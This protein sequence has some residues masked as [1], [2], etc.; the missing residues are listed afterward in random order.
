MFPSCWEVGHFPGK[1]K[2]RKAPQ[3]LPSHPP[4][5]DQSSPANSTGW[6]KATSRKAASHWTEMLL[7]KIQQVFER[8]VEIVWKLLKSVKWNTQ[9]LQ[10]NISKGYFWEID[11]NWRIW[12]CLTQ[13]SPP[14]PSN[15]YWCLIEDTSVHRMLRSIWHALHC[16]VGGPAYW[17]Y[18]N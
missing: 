2:S 8:G 15:K 3:S 10:Y 13:D 7:Q 11:R 16:P 9:L 12:A 5:R 1:W 18:L 17:Q 6:R 14:R 4:S